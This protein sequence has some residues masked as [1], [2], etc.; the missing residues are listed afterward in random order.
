MPRRFRVGNLDDTIVRKYI[1]I[2]ILFSA[3]CMVFQKKG[4]VLIRSM[5][6]AQRDNDPNSTVRKMA[7]EQRA[8]TAKAEAAEEQAQNRLD[9][10]F[11]RRL[12]AVGELPLDL[13]RGEVAIYLFNDSKRGVSFSIMRADKTKFTD[14]V[15]VPVGRFEKV[16]IKDDYRIYVR[17]N[18]GVRVWVVDTGTRVGRDKIIIPRAFGCVYR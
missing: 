7:A 9:A 1:V 10:D 16:L 17:A 6:Y 4:Q 15:S 14:D 5:G 11:V 12:K 8:L 13:S 18:E 2:C 3:A